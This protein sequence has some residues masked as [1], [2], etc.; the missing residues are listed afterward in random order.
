MSDQI[1]YLEIFFWCYDQTIH[2]IS[3]DAR[4]QND[5]VTNILKIQIQLTHLESLKV[6]FEDFTE[7]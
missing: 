1:A 5:I 6:T 2:Q 7:H 4:Y 3:I